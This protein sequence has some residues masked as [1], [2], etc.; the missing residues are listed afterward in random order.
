MGVSMKFKRTANALSCAFLIANF[1]LGFTVSLR[2]VNSSQPNE[3]ATAIPTILHRI[4]L[5]QKNGKGVC[6]SWNLGIIGDTRTFTHKNNPTWEEWVWGEDE[7]ESL[8]RK[9]KDVLQQNSL[10]A[11]FPDVYRNF[12]T[13]VKRADSMRYLILYTYGGAYM[14]LDISCKPFQSLLTDANLVLRKGGKNN[15]MV[16][17]PHQDFF[18]RV[19]EGIVTTAN[20]GIPPGSKIPLDLSKEVGHSMNPIRATGEHQLQQVLVNNMD[21]KYKVGDFAGHVRV[22]DQDAVANYSPKGKYMQGKRN[23]NGEPVCIHRAL[24]SW[25]E[26]KYRGVKAKETTREER[27]ESMHTECPDIYENALHGKALMEK[28]HLLEFS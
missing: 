9:N 18:L 12:D 11:K 15:F 10:L 21:I 4:F 19:L 7:I 25:A 26:E 20:T 22:L 1:E 17:A 13:W 6:G 14:D 2:Q 24:N 8:F 5:P 3:P 27:K 28:A 23:V 16:A